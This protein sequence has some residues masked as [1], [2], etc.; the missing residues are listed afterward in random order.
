PPSKPAR[1][2]QE[3]VNDVLTHLKTRSTV[4]EEKLINVLRD[5]RQLRKKFPE[6]ENLLGQI[7]R[8]YNAVRLHSL[9]DA[10]EA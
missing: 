8:R 1:T 10:K 6:A 7:Q 4:E 9:K 5:R 2:Y 3:K